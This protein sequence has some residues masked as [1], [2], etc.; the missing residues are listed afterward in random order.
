MIFQKDQK[1]AT[2]IY[3]Q[4]KDIRYMELLVTALSLMRLFFRGHL[5]T[6]YASLIPN[7][8]VQNC[9]VYMPG[10][11]YGIAIYIHNLYL[12]VAWSANIDEATTNGGCMHRF[13]LLAKNNEKTGI[14]LIYWLMFFFAY[15]S[16]IPRN[17][18]SCQVMQQLS[19]H[20]VPVTKVL[21]LPIQN[22]E[23]SL[24]VAING[25]SGEEKWGLRVRQQRE[26]HASPIVLLETQ[27]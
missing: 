5:A 18:L 25:L 26:A 14:Q 6:I 1:E 27:R 20:Q 17:L 10:Y 4:G 13:I 8:Y 19:S 24:L 2:T 7:T 9:Q 12:L 11:M 23:L 21:C 22:G 16:T 3:D 15:I